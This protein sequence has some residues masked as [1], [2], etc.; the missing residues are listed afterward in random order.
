MSTHT[1]NESTQIR[2]AGGKFAGTTYTTADE[3]VDFS[4]HEISAEEWAERRGRFLDDP[5][6]PQV[7]GTVTWQIFND[8]GGLV[9]ELPTQSVDFTEWAH[10]ADGE[11][12]MAIVDDGSSAEIGDNAVESLVDSG[13]LTR[14]D[15]GDQSVSAYADIDATYAE[16]YLHARTEA[17]GTTAPLHGEVRE[18]RERKLARIRERRRRRE[19]HEKVAKPNAIEGEFTD[20][21]TYVTEIDRQAQQNIRSMASEVS[22]AYPHAS[23][24]ELQPV[25]TD[26]M[27]ADPHYEVGRIYDANGNE[28]DDETDW[29]GFEAILPGDQQRAGGADTHMVAGAGNRYSVAS[30]LSSPIDQRFEQSTPFD[31]VSRALAEKTGGPITA[32]RPM[33]SDSGDRFDGRVEV[34]GSPNGEDARIVALSGHDDEAVEALDWYEGRALARGEGRVD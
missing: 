27:D 22:A 12:L 31:P 14:P 5:H 15:F 28:V 1:F 16:A 13:H 9:Q 11:V 32:W 4:E 26:D 21:R 29:R 20:A 25:G 3:A 30:A 18:S 17:M 8:R 33:W 24:F 10:T 23:S 7:S 19:A 34:V 2:D 6:V